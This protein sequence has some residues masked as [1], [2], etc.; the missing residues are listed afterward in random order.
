MPTTLRTAHRITIRCPVQHDTLRDVVWGSPEALGRD[1]AIAALLAAIE[2]STDIGNFGRYTGVCEVTVGLEA[3][4]PQAGADP[5]L[6][7]AGE[8]TVSPTATLTTYVSADVGDERLGEL[9]G[10]L[11]ELHPWEVPVIEVA[12]IRLAAAPSPSDRASA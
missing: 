9:I 4:T 8:R 12:T 2:H 3:F 1:P 5:T 6:G 11:A 7:R 10:R